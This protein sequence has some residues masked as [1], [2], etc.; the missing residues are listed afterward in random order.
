MW[1]ILL[2]TKYDKW[3]KTDRS[4]YF[5]LKETRSKVFVMEQGTYDAPVSSLT[6]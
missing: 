1:K 2:I 4:A 3:S 5:S 6:R